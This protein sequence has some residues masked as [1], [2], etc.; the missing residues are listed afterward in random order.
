MSVV[1]DDDYDDDDDDV[2]Y[3]DDVDCDAFAHTNY[4]F[5]VEYKKKAPKHCIKNIYVHKTK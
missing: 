2:D 4:P 3:D 5:S 1:H